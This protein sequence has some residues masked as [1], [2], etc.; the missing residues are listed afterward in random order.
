MIQ[1][2]VYIDVDG[3][4]IRSV[5]IFFVMNRYKLGKVC[6]RKVPVSCAAILNY[7][8]ANETFKAMTGLL[9]Q[10]RADYDKRL[11]DEIDKLAPKDQVAVPEVSESEDCQDSA[12]LIA[13]SMLRKLKT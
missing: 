5:P 12:A 8:G 1:A 10:L 13:E 6:R 7:Q 11:Q 9:P 4:L 3:V 2:S